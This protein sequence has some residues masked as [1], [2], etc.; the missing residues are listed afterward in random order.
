MLTLTFIT[1]YINQCSARAAQSIKGHHRPDLAR[2]FLQIIL[3]VYLGTND[4]NP[5]LSNKIIRISFVI[6]INQTSHPTN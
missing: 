2:H 3:M 4:R 1:R 6:G 5:T